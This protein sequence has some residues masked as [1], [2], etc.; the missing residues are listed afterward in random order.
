MDLQYVLLLIGTVIVAVIAFNALDKARLMRHLRRGAAVL[1]P[2]I[3]ARA[4]LSGLDI[5]PPPTATSDKRHLSPDAA[6][7]ARP[8]TPEQTLR[9]ELETIEEMATMPLRL[10]T[11]S[12]ERTRE[13]K[14]DER[15]DFILNLP[16]ELE[17]PR[18]LALGI[19]KQHEYELEK[20]RKLFG[21][22]HRSG[23]W[24]ELARDPEHTLYGELALAIQMVDRSGPI[25]ESELNAFAQI[26]LKLADALHRPTK[27][28]TS[29]EQALARAREIQ[30]FCEAYD[31]IAGVNVAAREGQAF[32]GRAIELAARKAGM[33]LGAMNIFQLKN[34]ISPGCS[35]LF[36]LANLYEPG[37]FDPAQ[38]DTFE[39]GGLALFMSVPCAHHPP[40]VF[41][42]MIDA[43][44][45]LCEALGGGL[46]DQDMRPLTREGLAVIRGQI[47][48]IED[49][50][51]AF[52]I[53]PGEETALKLF[54]ENA[55]AGK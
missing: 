54:G 12:E 32:K 10:R 39:T 30:A 11:V 47:E 31:V 23:L 48:I 42:K 28:A 49:K 51:R 53:V 44:R 46:F 38:W 24:T 14:P 4:P 13:A 15:L 20:P 18:N 21:Q 35:H 2:R 52:G 45:G 26:G 40:A 37:A 36:S 3:A 6:T 29:F 8:K 7:A 1:R 55:A 9:A 33:Q 19:F 27:F 34:E 16:G 41:D 22:R 43:A 17:A 25:G 50:M 5:N